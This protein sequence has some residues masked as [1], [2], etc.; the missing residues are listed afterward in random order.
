[1]NSKIERLEHDLAVLK[2]QVLYGSRLYDATGCN[3]RFIPFQAAHREDIKTLQRGLE[4]EK[5]L[6]MYSDTSS[7]R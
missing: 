7:S 5:V 6:P 2:A 1:M 4:L 3:C